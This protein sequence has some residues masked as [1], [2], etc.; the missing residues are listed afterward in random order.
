MS[1]KGRTYRWVRR[2]G[3]VLLMPSLLFHLP[4]AH[5]VVGGKEALLLHKTL[6]SQMDMGAE[7][8]TGIVER[9]A[10]KIHGSF[11]IPLLEPFGKGNPFIAWGWSFLN[12]DSKGFC[13]FPLW[14]S[15]SYR[16]DTRAESLGA[17]TPTFLHKV[18]VA[19]HQA[20]QR[21]LHSYPKQD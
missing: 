13:L 5:H 14:L 6:A 9:P 2:L 16:Q 4:R 20:Q 7:C 21:N 10:R 8:Y 12:S 19:S 17:L 11:Q 1:T 3:T 15:G 18:Y